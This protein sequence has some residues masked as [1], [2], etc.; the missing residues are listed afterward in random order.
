MTGPPDPPDRGDSPQGS[1][2]E[3]HAEISREIEQLC[4]LKRWPELDEVVDR[5]VVRLS[6][7]PEVFPLEPAGEVLASLRKR[8]RFAKLQRVGEALLENGQSAPRVQRQIVQA[9]IDQG[10][11]SEAGS[12]LEE[13]L[14]ATANQPGSKEWVEARGLHGRLRKQAYV[15]AVKGDRSGHAVDRF[16]RQAIASYSEAW[17]YQP[18]ARSDRA[19]YE[20]ANH[21]PGINLVACAARAEREELKIPQPVAWRVLAERILASIEEDWRPDLRDATWSA[22]SA[23]EACVALER[24]DAAKIWLDR[25]LASPSA[26]AF[27]FASTSRQLQEVWQ[28]EASDS[29]PGALLATLLGRRAVI[30]EGDLQIL[31]RELQAVHGHEGYVPAEWVEQLQRTFRAVVRIEHGSRGVGSGFVVEGSE[32]HEN[33]RGHQ[34]VLTNQHV[35]SDSSFKEESLTPSQVRLRFSEGDAVR[36]VKRQLW[37]PAGEGLDVSI[38]QVEGDQPFERSLYLMA[39]KDLGCDS[40][41]PPRLYVI[42]YPGGGSLHVSLYDNRFVRVEKNSILYRSPTDQGHSGSPV[43]NE[44]FDAVAIHCAARR[45]EQANEGVL[46]DAVRTRLQEE[47][48]TRPS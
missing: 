10:L 13:L 19:A 18:A 15:E 28:L 38:L 12:A 43:M 11:L 32:L 37:P 22:A 17:S 47:P 33:L 30:D 20:R 14:P 46:I 5:L 24:M 25:Y 16:L 8:R 41:P 2:P 45:A 26:D 4:R 27:E 21:W 3:P 1:Q 7:G 35:V 42:G 23:F 34:V 40:E 44:N 6:E 48:P 36:R 39:L 9:Y 31:P 29:G